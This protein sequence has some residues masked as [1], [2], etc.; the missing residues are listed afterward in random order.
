MPQFWAVIVVCHGISGGDPCQLH[1][2]GPLDVYSC[3]RAV[4]AL[5]AEYAAA[6]GWCGA[7]LPH[8]STPLPAATGGAIHAGAERSAAIMACS[9]TTMLRAHLGGEKY[10][11][12]MNWFGLSVDG[13]VM[14]L[15]LADNTWTVLESHP[16]GMSCFRAAGTWSSGPPLTGTPIHNP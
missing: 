4:A 10:G 5:R 9:R 3:P 13:T 8:S 14:E 12:Q 1:H 16:N 11:E 15:W 2:A 6:G 7:V